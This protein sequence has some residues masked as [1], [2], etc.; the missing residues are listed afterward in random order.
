MNYQSILTLIESNPGMLLLF[1]VI[2]SIVALE[3]MVYIRSIRYILFGILISGLLFI[4]LSYYFFGFSLLSLSPALYFIIGTSILLSLT[5]VLALFIFIL[6]LIDL[7]LVLHTFFLMDLNSIYTW[8]VG[9]ILAIIF[10]LILHY[11]GKKLNKLVFE[12]DDELKRGATKF[13]K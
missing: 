5:F 7:L 9:I 11:Y 1:T 3:A 4:A 13:E 8:I 10:Y 2:V 12:I 6:L